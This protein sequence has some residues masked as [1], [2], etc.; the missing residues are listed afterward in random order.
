MRGPRKMLLT[1]GLCRGR[2]K[3]RYGFVV[4]LCYRS[5][6]SATSPLL[7]PFSSSYMKDQ[8]QSIRTVDLAGLQEAEIQRLSDLY[9]GR[10]V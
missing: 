9:Q 1:L 6:A 8:E 7:F 10:V 4:S 3:L 2:L 5:K